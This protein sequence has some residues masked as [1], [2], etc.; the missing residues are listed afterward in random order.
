MGFV[1][2]GV[3]GWLLVSVCCGHLLPVLCLPTF[4]AVL[5]GGV[6]GTA[7]EGVL[8]AG[9]REGRGSSGM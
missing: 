5:V 3:G 6:L 8:R 7:L 9:H 1:V 2:G 4:L